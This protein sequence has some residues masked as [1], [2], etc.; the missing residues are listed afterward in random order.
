MRGSFGVCLV[1]ERGEPGRSEP[2]S[3]AVWLED[4]RVGFAPGWNI[5][6]RCG[7]DSSI[8]IWRTEPL[9]PGWV[10]PAQGPQ[11]AGAADPARPQAVFP[12]LST[13]HWT[14]WLR[15][16]NQKCNQT[17]DELAPSLKTRLNPTQPTQ[18][19]DHVDPLLTFLIMFT[20]VS[21]I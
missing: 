5:P 7:L 6:L 12:I 2:V 14:V 1:G 18:P 8:K 3:V 17:L 20:A 16:Q 4:E 21:H 19:Q 9:Q 13:K 15:P 11:T 10:G